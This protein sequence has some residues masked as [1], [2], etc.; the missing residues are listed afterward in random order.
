MNLKEDTS[1]YCNGCFINDSDYPSKHQDAYNVYLG[2]FSWHLHCTC[3]EA[4]TWHGIWKTAENMTWSFKMFYISRYLFYILTNDKERFPVLAFAAVSTSNNIQS[5]HYSEKQ[6]GSSKTG[7]RLKEVH[8]IW[9][10]WMT[11]QEK[12]DL[13]IRVIAL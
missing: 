10:F 5:S 11:G 3:R 7:D 1:M 13:I 4:V 12:G 6:W 8:F 9:N 2:M